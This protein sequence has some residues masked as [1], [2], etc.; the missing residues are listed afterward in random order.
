MSVISWLLGF[1][2]VVCSF[3]ITLEVLKHFLGLSVLNSLYS[4]F[5]HSKRENIFPPSFIRSVGNYSDTH[6]C[7]FHKKHNASINNP[8]ENLAVSLNSVICLYLSYYEFFLCASHV[9]ER[10]IEWEPKSTGYPQRKKLSLAMPLIEKKAHWELC[11]SH[12][13][14]LVTKY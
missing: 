2:L 5:L 8:H 9:N 6:V 11:L 14:G 7:K 12:L 3:H 10:H 1:H 13:P 4:R